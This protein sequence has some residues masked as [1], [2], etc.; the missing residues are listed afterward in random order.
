MTE[1]DLRAFCDAKHPQ[2]KTPFVLDGWEYAASS[3][4]SVRVPSL[5]ATTSPEDAK[6]QQRE[7]RREA[8]DQ[9]GQAVPVSVELVGR[10]CPVCLGG[11]VILDPCTD[12]RCDRVFPSD[13]PCPVCGGGGSL[14]YPEVV[15]IEGQ[16]FR[17]EDIHKLLALPHLA[18]IV[19]PD[20]D[21]TVHHPRLF[22]FDGGQALLIPV[23]PPKGVI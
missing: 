14:P 6:W 3:T 12:P 9:K 13:D 15:E 5:S 22:T 19:P 18:I 10:T 17:G 11:G 23:D 8:W 20:C 16:W 1:P 2:R 4:I 7:P 21:T